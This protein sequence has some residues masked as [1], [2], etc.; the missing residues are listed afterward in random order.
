MGVKYIPWIDD[1]E[2]WRLKVEAVKLHGTAGLRPIGSHRSTQLLPSVA[3]GQRT[4]N[5]SLCACL[6]K[7]LSSQA[8]CTPMYHRHWGALISCVVGH[9]VLSMSLPNFS[10]CAIEPKSAARFQRC[11]GTASGSREIPGILYRVWSSDIHNLY[12]NWESPNLAA[13]MAALSAAPSTLRR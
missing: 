5:S 4:L 10:P 13:K 2:R 9:V 11:D 6:T 1:G 7:P 12:M 3:S 8:G